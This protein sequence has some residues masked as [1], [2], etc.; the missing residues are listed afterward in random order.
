V[1]PLLRADP[2]VQLVRLYESVGPVFRSRIPGQELVFAIGPEANRQLLMGRPEASSSRD[3]HAQFMW[4]FGEPL[5]TL[6]GPEHR[7]V[8]SGLQGLFRGKELARVTPRMAHVVERA[9]ASWTTVPLLR[10]TSRLSLEVILSVVFGADPADQAALERH[11]RRFTRGFFAP[12]STLPGTPAWL[13]LRARARIDSWLHSRIA[14]SADCRDDAGPCLIDL[15]T[16]AAH[17]SVGCPYGAMTDAQLLDNLR[18]L[19]F[20]GRE[21]TASVMAWALIEIARDATL[22][23]RLCQEVPRGYPLPLTVADIQALPVV[24]AVIHESL[25]RY[26]PA[27]LIARG[28]RSDTMTINGHAL[29]PGTVVAVSPLATHHLPDVWSAPFRFDIDRWADIGQPDPSVYLPFGVGPHTCL[30]SA[31]AQVEMGQVLVALLRRRRR[32][33]LAHHRYDLRPRLLPLPRPS[34]RIRLHLVD[35]KD[36]T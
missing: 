27:W 24:Q 31:F 34:R 19:I 6:D 35:E 2:A 29:A 30:G 5:E 23:A 18:I 32:P 22:W 36:T 33:Y 1:L 21:T 4:L 25:R 14:R 13:S 9:V 15:L 3:G 16:L 10:A 8:R 28:V 20:A 11:Y 12:R 7:Q 17:P 26:T